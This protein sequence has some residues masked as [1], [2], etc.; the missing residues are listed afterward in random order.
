MKNKSIFTGLSWL[1]I[2]I[3]FTSAYLIS[4]FEDYNLF[5]LI[6][7]G[8]NLILGMS[9]AAKAP[10]ITLTIARIS[11]GLLFVYSGLVKGVD[12]LG[13]QFRIEDYFYAFNTLWAIPAALPLS[14]L[15]NAFE[16]SL[17]V[18]LI[19]N[20]RMRLLSWVVTLMMLVFGVITLNDALYSPVPDCGCF[21]DALI[22][23]N[24]Q[25][26]YKN[27][28]I[29]AFVFFILLRNKSFVNL[30]P[31]KFQYTLMLAIFAVFTLF[32]VYTVRH[33]PL[34]D[35]RD[36]KVGN[37]LLP[38]NP[39][40]AKFYFTYKNSQSG[41][42]R[43][44]LSS[45]L[46]WQDSVFMAEWTYVSSREIN[47]DAALY[48]TFPMLDADGNDLSNTL[49][50]SEHPVFFMVVYNIEKASPKALKKFDAIYQE[51]QKKGWD[52]YLLNSDL[53]EV[54]AKKRAEYEL[55]DYPVLSSDDT[56]LK[57][58]IRSNPGLIIVRDGVVRMKYNQRDIPSWNEMEKIAQQ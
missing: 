39:Q 18:F 50:A 55:G 1:F 25:T 26:F 42:K 17:G 5:F 20:L 31:A 11:V 8:V 52:F 45:E 29:T 58:A 57:A 48:K 22:I 41:E 13:T 46:P 21:G 40:P 24:W 56:A 27:I 10:K 14:L 6:L 44:Y 34:M 33:L 7:L 35:F 43:E 37:R 51:C 15:L 2:A 47:P 53:P 23:T 16:F 30:R 36:W 19:L 28:V 4:F 38:E 3:V 54:L 9:I 32:E 12:P 49:V